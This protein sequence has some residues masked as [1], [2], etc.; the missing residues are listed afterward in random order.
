MTVKD[1]TT[2]RLSLMI[3]PGVLTL[4]AFFLVPLGSVLVEAGREHALARFF[5]SAD[6]LD[7]LLRSV[8][9]GVSA[10]LVALIVGV[11]V[12]LHLSRMS[13]RV[14]AVLQVLIALPLTFSGLIVAT[15]SSWCS[16]GPVS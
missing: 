3:A 13:P 5:G 9:L 14:R 6:L 10:G 2:L 12:A 8:V 4:G 15:V 11:P 7:A 16:A 1:R